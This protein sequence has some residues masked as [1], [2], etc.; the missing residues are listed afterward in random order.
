MLC[1]TPLRA[2]RA[3]REN[4]LADFADIRRSA[5]FILS[6]RKNSPSFTQLC[7]LCG[8][9]NFSQISQIFADSFSISSMCSMWLNFQYSNYVSLF[10]NSAPLR[11]KPPPASHSSAFLRE[12]LCAP[13]RETPPSV[14]KKSLADFTDLRRYSPDFFYVFYVVKFQAR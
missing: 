13:L 9:K 3:L 12:N 7:E 4:F 6:A 10:A 1:V 14:R 11:E 5:F 2:L 8:E